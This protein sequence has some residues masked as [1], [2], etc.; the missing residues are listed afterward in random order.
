MNNKNQ[1]ILVVDDVNEVKEAM[2]IVLQ[3][4]GYTVLSARNGVEALEVVNNNHIDLIITDILMPEMDGYEL[5]KEIQASYPS[6]KLILISGGGRTLGSGSRI[7]YLSIGKQ[8]TGVAHVLK[9]PIKPDML[10]KTIDDLFHG[11]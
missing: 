10:L 6:I 2:M 11:E 9:K 7:D 1:N 3:D 4:D 8:L 5:A